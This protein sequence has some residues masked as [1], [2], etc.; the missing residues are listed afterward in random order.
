MSGVLA[1]IA[2]VSTLVAI[3]DDP[4]SAAAAVVLSDVSVDSEMGS[5][6]PPFEDIVGHEHELPISALAES[7]P[8]FRFFKCAEDLFCPDDPA[9]RWLV[10]VWLH[11][12]L[13]NRGAPI[14]QNVFA[15]AAGDD[16]W[17]WAKYASVLFEMG[18]TTGCKWEPLQFC[19]DRTVTRGQLAAFLSRAF[20]LTTQ[21]A[22]HPFSDSA[23]SIF[24]DAIAAVYEHRISG[25]EPCNTDPLEYC[26]GRP[27]T[28]GQLAAGIWSALRVEGARRTGDLCRV[29]GLNFG[30]SGHRE[31]NKSTSGFVLPKWAWG[32]TLGEWS[33]AMVFTTFSGFPATYETQQESESQIAQ[34]EAYVDAMSGGRLTLDVTPLHG[35]AEID[36]EYYYHGP[37]SGLGQIDPVALKTVRRAISERGLDLDAYHAVMVV[38]P[39]EWFVGGYARGSGFN[40]TGIWHSFPTV[41]INT[42]AQLSEG[43]QQWWR[44]AA[45]E[46]MHLLGL[47]D[48]YPKAPS[49]N[50]PNYKFEDG[51]QW[52]TSKLGLMGLQVQH[53]VK[54]DGFPI[55][56]LPRESDQPYTLYDSSFEAQEMLGWS[57]WQLGWLDDEQVVCLEEPTESEVVLTPGALASDAD[58]VLIVVGDPRQ[59]HAYAIESRRAVRYDANEGLVNSP[60]LWRD[61]TWRLPEEGVVVY[62]VRANR[63]S[64]DLPLVLLP[65]EGFGYSTQSPFLKE[66]DSIIVGTPG[67]VYGAFRVEVLESGEGYDRVR[68]TNILRDGS[69]PA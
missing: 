40:Y 10:A 17:R 5:S 59:N 50:P 56:F 54:S 16:R 66:G 37:L 39:S 31:H 21:A 28:R 62:A 60:G 14:I 34:L 69:V 27:V 64:P 25:L 63:K 42:R 23:D 8:R 6:P 20:G 38:L 51:H 24:A 19:P 30:W 43:P 7:N 58:Q 44:T 52:G 41:V 3:S 67:S 36:R 65:D 61:V 29:P 12:A 46:L 35:W 9:P 22:S 2:V 1:A 13:T 55:S 4:K 45:H 53:P 15:D 11:D 68:V 18:V 48:L 47:A 49:Y 33:V 57:R 26:A 32:K